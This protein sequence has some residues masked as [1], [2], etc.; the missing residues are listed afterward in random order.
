[1][2]FKFVKYRIAVALLVTLQ[3]YCDHRV[4]AKV[5]PSTVTFKSV[6]DTCYLNDG[7]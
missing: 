7:S 6:S 1:M 4:L 2:N 3:R 5:E